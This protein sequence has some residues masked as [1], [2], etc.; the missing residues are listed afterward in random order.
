MLN[1]FVG[2]TGLLIYFISKDPK[3]SETVRIL[4]FCSTLA[5]LLGHAH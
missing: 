1:V 4:F 2:L 5:I 3:L